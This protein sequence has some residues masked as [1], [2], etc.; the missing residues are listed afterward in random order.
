MGCISLISAYDVAYVVKYPSNLDSNEV[1]VKDVLINQGYDV[2]VLDDVSFD[3]GGYDVV[4]VSERVNSIG[5]IFDN[6]NTKTFFMSSSAAKSQGL[7][8][9]S[10]SS[11]GRKVVITDNDH[12]I[13]DGFSIGEL[14]VYPSNGEMNYLNGYRA[15]NSDSLISKSTDD[16]D[17]ILLLLDTNALLLDGSCTKRDLELYE[18]NLFFGLSEASNWNLNA[19]ALFVG[20]FNWLV[21]EDDS[22]GDGYSGV[23]DCN[24]NDINI[25]P[26]AVEILDNVDQNCVNDAPVLVQDIRAIVLEENENNENVIDLYEYFKDPD[27]DDLV[28]SVHSITN[29]LDVTVSIENSLVSFD[30][31]ELDSNEK[32]VFKANDGNLD[33]LSNEVILSAGD[34][35]SCSD[36]NGFSCSLGRVC[37]GNWLDFANTCC[38]V[39]CTFEET[40]DFGD[41]DR[42]LDKLNGNINIDIRKPLDNAEFVPGRAIETRIEIE[43][44][45]Q[46]D[47]DFDVDIY[48][49]DLDDD[50]VI[51]SV[52]FSVNL[53]N[54]ER[55]NIDNII[56][57]EGDIDTSHNYAVLVTVIDEDGEYYN[58]DYVVITFKRAEHDVIIEKLEI[59]P[60]AVSC[61][62]YVTVRARVYNVGENDE[63]V[64]IRLKNTE[65][66]I[67][68][69]SDEFSL[70]RYDNDD[71]KIVEFRVEIPSGV[72]D[73]EYVLRV[74][75]YFSGE[76]EYLEGVLVVGGCEEGVEN[77]IIDISNVE[78]VGSINPVKVKK[79]GLGWQIGLLVT[80]FVVLVGLVV[81]LVVYRKNG[82]S[83]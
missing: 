52:G 59:S 38:S 18:R 75:S 15:I 22:D 67:D 41:V 7:T 64:Y 83:S 5:S 51:E 2:D 76:S 39:T 9:G 34:L 65:L 35:G 30:V 61:G 37:G 21:D 44:K 70:E 31:G 16:R 11:V 53:E 79:Q 57:V 69:R 54:S 56:E 48:L 42:E 1:V 28:F 13:T 82:Y 10:G 6:R 27:G 3:A 36:L 20:A 12:M 43:N 29:D 33:V 58:E 24:D 19:E 45:L 81:M 60:G 50:E 40:P 80:S 72:A 77:D 49:Y 4:V 66:G 46:E 26:G 47:L 17:I 73:G 23:E 74:A 78:S 55:K 8:S 14:N 68:E 25:H 71:T 63:E 32:V 62:G